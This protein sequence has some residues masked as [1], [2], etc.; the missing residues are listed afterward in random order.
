MI[1]IFQ[2]YQLYFVSS[3]INYV[4][5]A[6]KNYQERIQLFRDNLNNELDDQQLKES[7]TLNQHHKT[8]QNTLSDNPISSQEQQITGN[9]QFNLREQNSKNQSNE[10]NDFQISE[11]DI[12]QQE[13]LNNNEQ[14]IINQNNA[15][16]KNE[17]DKNKKENNKDCQVR[18]NLNDNKIINQQKQ[19]IQNQKSQQQPPQP[20][21]VKIQP[22]ES[23]K[24][25]QSYTSKVENNSE[26]II[27]PVDQ[28]IQNLDQIKSKVKQDTQR[29]KNSQQESVN[30]PQHSQQKENNN[31]NE[32]NKQ[33]PEI[34]NQNIEI[35]Q[36]REIQNQ[37]LIQ[38]VMENKKKEQTDKTFSC[39]Q[40]TQEYEKGLQKNNQNSEDQT[41]CIKKT[42]N[43]SD[44]LVSVNEQ[45]LNN[46]NQIFNQKDLSVNQNE[47]FQNSNNQLQKEIK[48]QDSSQKILVAEQSSSQLTISQ[49]YFKN[50][51]KES[52]K[53]QGRGE[54]KN[55]ILNQET[56]KE[57]NQPQQL[58]SEN[59]SVMKIDDKY[60]TPQKINE[61]SCCSIF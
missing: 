40:I 39:N 53:K 47:N 10:Q 52:S 35:E 7:T 6:K 32:I 28:Q 57:L 12:K 24:N 18:Q 29:Q 26:S 54:F 50:E 59:Q 51:I 48:E 20:Y 56:S 15:N 44:N 13:K 3:Q 55:I 22:K 25:N 45:L 27:K 34:L 38:Q 17:I 9:D 58:Q 33:L 36:Q 31:K 30:V 49:N 16:L 8:L 41:D 1:G 61:S 4:F 2:N 14:K 19:N 42:K 43:L 60:Q 37:C 11:K 21:Q 5:I 23:L 46:Q